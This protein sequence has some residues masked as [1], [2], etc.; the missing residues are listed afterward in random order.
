MGKSLLTHVFIVM[1]SVANEKS[2]S[3][4]TTIA[5]SARLHENEK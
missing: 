3:L 4:L 1:G 2:K 5:R